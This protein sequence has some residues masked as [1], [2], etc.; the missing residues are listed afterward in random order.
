MNAMPL[1]TAE[2][3]RL[4]RDARARTLGLVADLSDEQFRIPYLSIINPWLWELGHIAWFQ[5]WW[6]LRTLRGEVPLM[7]GGDALYD[8]A[9]V[10][11]R[12]R[13]ALPLP[14]RAA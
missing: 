14:S 2:L 10:P 1:P 11:H 7:A 9:R 5:E 3:A 6:C 12:T 4:L 13:W 8:S